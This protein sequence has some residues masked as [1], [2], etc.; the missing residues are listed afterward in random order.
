MF[1]TDAGRRMR[2]AALL[3][4]AAL[5][6]GPGAG[7]AR[8][9]KYALLVGVRQY[10]GKGLKPLSWTEADMVDLAQALEK[11][12][13]RRENI[14]LMTDR[15]GAQRGERYRPLVANIRRELRQLLQGRTAADTVLVAFSGHGMQP[16]DTNA[17]YFCPLDT[18]PFNR[19]TMVS[20]GNVYRD[21][22]QCPA[23]FKLLLADACRN[24]PFK[25]SAS[26]AVSDAGSAPRPQAVPV[27]GGVAAFFA[28]S[29]GQEAYEFNSLKN[30]VFFHFVIEGLRGGARSPGSQEVTLAGLGSYVTRQV[31]DFVRRE[32]NRDQVPE[33]INRTRGP[34]TL[35]AGPEEE[36]RAAA[37][38]RQLQDL[39][40]RGQALAHRGETDK[41]LALFDQALKLDANRAEAHACRADALNDK[42][43]FDQALAECEQ[44]LRL[45]P[46]L[47]A[48]H[49]FRAD[50]YIGKRDFARAA[51]ACAQAL[52]IDPRLAGVYNDRGV[53]FALQGKPEKAVAE[54][55]K[56]LELDRDNGRAYGNR[57]SAYFEMG[58]YARAVGDYTEALRLGP[59]DPSAYYYRGVAHEK[60]GHTEL[61]R[62]DRT[63]ARQLGF[64][65]PK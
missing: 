62:S 18:D 45:D 32:E 61:A 39:L 48:A 6:V 10:T 46:R 13:F 8:A 14:V 11:S 26:R 60:L 56:A 20:L 65:P 52:E 28:C 64:T 49:E 41:A 51:R 37:L 5:V 16:T 40:S 55:T 34:V 19:R 35:V 9:E 2:W 23:T 29:K 12:G 42:G 36:R 15:V 7:L 25:A 43:Q 38:A 30:G 63:T 44:A 54:F 59:R 50:A 53:L 31:R 58:D 4:L 33:L 17:F 57:A 24:D 27:P 3:G 22:A 21:L 1:V 47:A